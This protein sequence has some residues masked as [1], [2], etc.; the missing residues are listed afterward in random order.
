MMWHR[1]R[2]L[3]VSLPWMILLESSQPTLGLGIGLFRRVGWLLLHG[4][5]TSNKAWHRSFL[6]GRHSSLCFK[7]EWLWCS[8][9][10]NAFPSVPSEDLH[11]PDWTPA[12]RCNKTG[13]SGLIFR[14]P[15]RQAVFAGLSLSIS[16]GSIE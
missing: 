11:C 8:I 12:G 9:S 10:V 15:P 3:G 7:A 6:S 16:L 2:G 14:H 5:D 4:T 1:R 13:K